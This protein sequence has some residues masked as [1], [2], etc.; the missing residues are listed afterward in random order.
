MKASGKLISG[1]CK[2]NGGSSSS[3]PITAS[4]AVNAREQIFQRR[5]HLEDH[6]GAKCCD[7]RRIAH[8]LN[9]IAEAL[10]G[11]KQDG[12][13]LDRHRAVPARLR[14]FPPACR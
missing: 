5:L 3:V 12:L 13:A 14:K 4:G 8:K 10:L 6:F 11:K 1:L 9:G 2:S 7:E